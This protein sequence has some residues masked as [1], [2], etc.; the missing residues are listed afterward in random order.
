MSRGK[1]T[2]LAAVK[3]QG[4]SF[5]QRWRLEL[6]ASAAAAVAAAVPAAAA[7]ALFARLGLRL[8]HGS[9]RPFISVPFVPSIAF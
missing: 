6:P 7:A 1:K 2:G 3:L 8:V 4:L 9:G 5:I